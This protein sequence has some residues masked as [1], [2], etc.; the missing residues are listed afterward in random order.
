MDKFGFEAL[1]TRW[2]VM[3]EDKR[4]SNKVEFGVTDLVTKFERTYSRFIDSSQICKINSSRQKTISLSQ[5][6]ANILDLGLE[7][8]KLSGGGFDPNVGQLMEGYGY[9]S[10]YSF[11]RDSDKIDSPRGD[12]ELN[13]TNLIK[14]GSLNL[15]L[16]GWGKGWLID[17]VSEYLKKLNIKYFLVDGGGDMY[18]TIK[19]SGKGWRIGL[20][21]PSDDDLVIAGVELK[22]EAVAGSNPAYRQVGD[23]HH[24]V[25]AVDGFPVDRVRGTYVLAPSAAVADGCA[26]ALF[27]SE[28]EFWPGL[29][30][31]F[32]ME[33]LV[34]GEGNRVIFQHGSKI[35]L[36]A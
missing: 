4:V 31:R 11:V 1:G 23:F 16:G 18:G 12:F 14:S 32:K 2:E 6:L 29:V 30:N 35:S 33:C 19:S 25:N 36:V 5:E 3:I 21:H 13:G 20:K 8:K 9:D 34:V 22:N 15:D 17:K 28:K 10:S 27:V 7:L 24:L 26:T